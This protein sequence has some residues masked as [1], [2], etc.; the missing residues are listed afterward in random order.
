[1]RQ[2]PE[3]SNS[4]TMSHKIEQIKKHVYTYRIQNQMKT[5]NLIGTACVTAAQKI[6]TRRTKVRCLFAVSIT[7]CVIPISS[8]SSSPSPSCRKK[9]RFSVRSAYSIYI[10][11][12]HG[13]ALSFIPHSTQ[14]CHVKIST[15]LA[16][17]NRTNVHVD[18]GEVEKHLYTAHSYFH[19]YSAQFWFQFCSARLYVL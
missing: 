7:F 8:S 5:K 14:Y 19:F 9:W 3:H 6:D 13:V 11:F 10:H 4:K 17:N 2:G 12:S 18:N 16:Y 15:V 1:M